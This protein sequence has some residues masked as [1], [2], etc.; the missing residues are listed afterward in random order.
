MP[1]LVRHIIPSLMIGVS[2]HTLSRLRRLLIPLACVFSV[3]PVVA[4][5][6]FP[7]SNDFLRGM[8]WRYTTVNVSVKSC[9]NHADQIRGTFYGRVFARISTLSDNGAILRLN[10]LPSCAAGIARRSARSRQAANNS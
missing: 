1:T 10:T 5:R 6:I 2:V 7:P 4:G 8:C 3:F 9:A